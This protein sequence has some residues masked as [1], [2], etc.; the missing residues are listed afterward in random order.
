MATPNVTSDMAQFFD[1]GDAAMPEVQPE[2]SRPASRVGGHR[3]GCPA[4][5]QEGDQG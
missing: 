4:F 2:M 3:I 5:G 1:F